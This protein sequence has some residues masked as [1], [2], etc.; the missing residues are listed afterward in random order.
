MKKIIPFIIFIT[1]LLTRIVQAE[2]I[3]GKVT[4]LFGDKLLMNAINN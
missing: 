1:L 3:K 4:Q 2:V